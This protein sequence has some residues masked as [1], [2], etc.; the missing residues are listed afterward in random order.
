MNRC[1][2]LLWGHLKDCM[3]RTDPDTVQDLEGEIETVTEEVTS[4]MLRDTGDSFVVRLQQGPPRSKVLILNMCS[5]EDNM[6]TN[7][8]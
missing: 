5:Y 3:S 7:C 8:P 6:N 1:V 4:D 2:F